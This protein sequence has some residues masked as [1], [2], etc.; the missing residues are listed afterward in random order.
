MGSG[1]WLGEDNGMLGLKNQTA[2]NGVDFLMIVAYFLS[3][4][5]YWMSDGH[6]HIEW[7]Q[8]FRKGGYYG[9]QDCHQETI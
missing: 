9:N 5:T 6:H 1:L 8:H 7:I 4:K 3:R 2:D